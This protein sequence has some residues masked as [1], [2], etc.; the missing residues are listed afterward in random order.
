MSLQFLPLA[1]NVHAGLDG[2]FVLLET[3]DHQHLAYVEGQ[4]GSQWV[5]D[6]DE[7]SIMARTYAMLRTQALT[8]LDSPGLLDRLLVSR[9]PVHVSSSCY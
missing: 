5:S 4:R 1:G 3:P 7:V 6:A 2:P 9:D 8:K